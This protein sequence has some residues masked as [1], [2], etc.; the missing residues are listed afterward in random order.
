LRGAAQLLLDCTHIKQVRTALEMRENGKV[1]LDSSQSEDGAAQF[2]VWIKKTVRQKEKRKK[3]EE[4]LLSSLPSPN[5]QRRYQ[6]SL[7]QLDR[8]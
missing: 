2:K 5:C 3:E 7:F 1:S 8:D 6:P 4:R